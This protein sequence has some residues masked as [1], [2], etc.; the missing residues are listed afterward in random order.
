[1]LSLAR[2]SAV[3]TI[4]SYTRETTDAVKLTL[5][6]L[7]FELKEYYSDVVV[8]GGAAPYLIARQ[9]FPH[10]GIEDIDFAVKPNIAIREETIREIIERLRFE[11][12]NVPS[13]FI[14]KVQSG[15]KEYRIELDFLCERKGLNSVRGNPPY[16]HLVQKDLYAA[17]YSGVSIA[18]EF[19]FKCDFQ[20]AVA[21]NEE[22]AFL[23]VMDLVA[24]LAFAGARER[25][26]DAYDVFAL[27][28]FNDGPEGA[29]EYF[30]QTVALSRDT[31][32]PQN[33]ECLKKNLKRLSELFET[34]ASKPHSGGGAYVRTFSEGRYAEHDVAEQVNQFLEPV[35]KFL[36]HYI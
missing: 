12:G 2:N 24:S 13:N 32:S 17:P 25:A 6:E 36:P 11:P 22:K 28:H 14:K 23:K 4:T 34:S 29:A 27:T 21:T 26:K 7:A 31:I 9:Y 8:I 20:R 35:N 19:N 5:H 30:I 16:Y 10:C 15:D 1:V 3:K 33:L 18:F